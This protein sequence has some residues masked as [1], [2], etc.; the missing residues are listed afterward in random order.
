M[1]IAGTGSC[2]RAMAVQVDVDPAWPVPGTNTW[3]C[4]HCTP[5]AEL[6]A[7]FAWRLLWHIAL[8]LAE[9]TGL[10][11]GWC[12][13][14]TRGV[15]SA[16]TAPVLWACGGTA[17]ALYCDWAVLVAAAG[18]RS[19]M[20]PDREWRSQVDRR[21]WAHAGHGQSNRNYSRGLGRDAAA[22]R[23]SLAAR[24]IHGQG[25]PADARRDRGSSE[26]P[27]ERKKYT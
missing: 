3:H 15:R 8:A 14:A 9:H 26:G 18:R 1:I 16:A 12:P 27:R 5:A 4:G 22:C 17:A 7:A 24:A 21:S 25:E 23:K 19:L 20:R 13:H 6:E 11:L 10:G 2:K